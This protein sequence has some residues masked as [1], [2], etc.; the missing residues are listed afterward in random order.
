MAVSAKRTVCRTNKARRKTRTRNESS[1]ANGQRKTSE[2][3]D[4]AADAGSDVFVSYS[5]K[6]KFWKEWLLAEP[7][8]T[9]GRGTIEPW[10]DDEIAGSSD[11]FEE[12]QLA[13][14][15]A[16]V[17]VL[18]VS[19]NFLNSEFIQLHE[20]KKILRK[21]QTGHTSVLWVP[22]D[23]SVDKERDGNKLMGIQGAWPAGSPLVEIKEKQPPEA[24]QAART[25]I[26]DE[27][28]RVLDEGWWR[29]ERVLRNRHASKYELIE[30]LGEGSSRDAFV[31]RD[32]VMK[33]WVAITS[34]KKHEPIGTFR[35]SLLRATRVNDID[36]FLTIY[37]ASLDTKPS[38]YVGHYCEGQT[39]EHRLKRGSLPFPFIRDLLLRLG[40][41]LSEAHKRNFFHLNIKPSNIILD[42]RD[43]AYLSPLSRRHEKYR[44]LPSNW[45][46]DANYGV[47][48]ED[49]AYLIPE[50]FGRAP[51]HSQ[52]AMS[53]QYL[54]GLV[55]YHMVTGV[56]PD[57]NA[58]GDHAPDSIDDFK[59]LTEIQEWPHCRSC[60]VLLSGT[61]M[62]MSQRFPEDRFDN[63]S[64]V[65]D[66]LSQLRNESLSIAKDSY[67]RI[68][69]LPRWESRVFGAFYRKFRKQCQNR[70]ALAKFNEMNWRRQREMLKEA[71]LLL[72]AYGDFDKS[73]G[74]EPTILTRVAKAHRK[75]RLTTDDFTSFRDILIQEFVSHDPDCQSDRF[76]CIEIR[77][78]WESA[79]Q[80]GL[81]YMI[82]N[83]R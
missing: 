77:R 68:A 32:H 74:A 2:E 50:F 25:R 81:D 52:Y 75:L 34:L 18:L 16:A 15:R 39:L 57:T 9:F 61:I 80:P 13:L 7:V 27:I 54:L 19:E 72:L 12:I 47:G 4:D 45:N 1:V 23:D 64:Q 44:R 48:G 30:R 76:M 3:I 41:A 73:D 67:R 40:T 62:K 28:R 35:R 33:R 43:R 78:A 53:D 42:E 11:W 82:Q 26:Y 20:L 38:F 65:L 21:R 14:Q 29:T 56:L 5:H 22:I 70:R 37:D 31:A 55:G 71:V 79:M 69:G 83:S 66:R 17:A 46:K 6:D 10:S 8:A 36:C 51:T 59:Q 49:R 63:L 58:S 60:P 24:L